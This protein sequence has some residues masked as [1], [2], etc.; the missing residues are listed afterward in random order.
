MLSPLC[1][2]ENWRS[3]WWLALLRL[4]SPLFH[5]PSGEEAILS[6]NDTSLSHIPRLK[7]LLMAFHPPVSVKGIQNGV[8]HT[9]DSSFPASDFVPEFPEKKKEEKQFE[10]SSDYMSLSS[11]LVIMRWVVG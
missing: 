3:I 5:Q 8:I 4:V 6:L 10:S 7:T 2:K 9:A 11:L 1:K